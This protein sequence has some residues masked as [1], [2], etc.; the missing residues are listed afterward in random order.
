MLI[1]LLFAVA[2]TGE[3]H[4]TS[5]CTNLRALP[6]C[7]DEVVI[8]HFTPKGAKVVHLAADK[9]VA[10]KPESMGEFAG[11]RAKAPRPGSSSWNSRYGGTFS[12]PGKST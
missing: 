10:G 4:G 3:W 8:Y 6:G 11:R 12:V 9:I 7:H 1:S 2:L 5:L